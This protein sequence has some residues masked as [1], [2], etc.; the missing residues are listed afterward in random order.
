MLVSHSE[1]G[2][3]QASQIA[4][5]NWL[6]VGR[7]ERDSVGRQG[8]LAPVLCSDCVATPQRAAKVSPGRCEAFRHS[9]LDSI[10]DEAVACVARDFAVDLEELIVRLDQG[11]PGNARSE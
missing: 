9:L 8:L 5:V 11:D 10:A 1:T 6:E 7:P 4:D 2:A 3:G